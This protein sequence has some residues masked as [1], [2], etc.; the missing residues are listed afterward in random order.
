VLM[1]LGDDLK[2]QPPVTEPQPQW[3]RTGVRHRRSV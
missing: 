3:I 1:R 2:R